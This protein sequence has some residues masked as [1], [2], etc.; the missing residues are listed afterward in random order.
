MKRFDVAEYFKENDMHTISHLHGQ[1]CFEYPEFKIEDTN[2]YAFQES[3]NTLYKYVDF[4]LAKDY[5]QRYVRSSD[6]TQSGENLFRTNIL[7][8]LMK[9]DKLLWNPLNVYHNKLLNSLLKNKKLIIIGYGFSDL[10]INNLLYQ[11]NALHLSDRKMLMI[12]YV[13]DDDWKQLVEHPFKPSEKAIFTNLMR[14]D[15]FWCRTYKSKQ[16]KDVI[17]S[18]DNMTCICTEGFNSVCNNHMME[19][20]QFLK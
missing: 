17:I 5:R 16:Q 14:K 4:K 1:I 2:N 13:S 7:T 3:H 8:G 20:K 6:C 12:D 19:I 18:P 9:T 15:D 11:Y 10:Y